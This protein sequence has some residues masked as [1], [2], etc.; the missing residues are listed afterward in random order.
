MLTYFYVKNDIL[1]FVFIQRPQRLIRTT[2]TRPSMLITMQNQDCS[3]CPSLS[4]KLCKSLALLSSCVWR[5]L[6]SWGTFQKSTIKW[7]RSRRK[8]MEGSESPLLMCCF[9]LEVLWKNE[10]LQAS[11]NWCLST[12]ST[13]RYSDSQHTVSV[14]ST[15][16]C[17][18][19]SAELWTTIVNWT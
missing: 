11:L 12:R 13:L 18:Q 6:R 5:L 17:T 10:N 2:W 4:L 8:M 14:F 1:S 9:C 15:F 3:D 16:L 19:P 7:G